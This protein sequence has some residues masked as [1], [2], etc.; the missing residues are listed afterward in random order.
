MRKGFTLIELMIVIAIIAIIA[1]IA[2]P[3]LLESRVTANEAAA[4]ASLKS[5][6]FPAQVQFQAGGYQDLDQD[7]VGEY[8]TLRA[9]AGLDN[10]NKINAG[11]IRL[12][13]GPLA[14]TGAWS[15]VAGA[16]PGT[17]A[18]GVASGYSFAG[19]AA[20]EAEANG[21]AVTTWAEGVAG[22]LASTLVPGN[23]ANNG[24]RYWIAVCAPESFGDTGR[25]PFVISE[26]GQVRSP[27]TSAGVASFYTAVT[28]IPDPTWI[29][30][31]D[32]DP[33]TNP[34][35]NIPDPN[36]INNVSNGTKVNSARVS[37]GVG[38]VYGLAEQAALSAT[39]NS[40]SNN[41]T[42]PVYAK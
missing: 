26:D 23:T 33:L 10:T 40:W 5:G 16:A 3:N 42:F 25:R 15:G 1:A 8:A 12:L 22:Q 28:M 21:T 32:G 24:E 18:L 34:Q 36:T 30:D 4:S 11:S 13:T 35:P 7:N 19:F 31:G 6:V 29:D 9:L 37:I 27:A 17:P 2:I 20:G 38:I 39:F 41:K 14:T